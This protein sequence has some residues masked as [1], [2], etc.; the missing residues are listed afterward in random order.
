M[1]LTQVCTYV[2]LTSGAFPK[3]CDK[4]TMLIR[5]SGLLLS[6]KRK[7]KKGRKFF[8]T[9]P[10]NSLHYQ[11]EVLSDSTAEFIYNEFCLSYITCILDDALCLLLVTQLQL[12]RE[13]HLRFMY[14]HVDSTTRTIH[15]P[16]PF[17]C[18]W[19]PMIANW[20]C[21]TK[22]QHINQR[23]AVPQMNSTV[24]VQY[25]SGDKLS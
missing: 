9:F 17:S 2:I 18:S 7:V 22:F 20:V 12:M 11:A 23:H 8:Y 24:H 3:C 25:L 5:V 1:L 16:A 15:V 6:Y 19:L 4:T 21:F 10:N 13:W 14:E